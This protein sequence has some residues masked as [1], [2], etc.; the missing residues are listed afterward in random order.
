MIFPS[1]TSRKTSRTIFFVR[2]RPSISGT[3]ADGNT[4]FAGEYAYVGTLSLGG[5]MEGYLYKSASQDAGEFTYFFMMPDTPET[6]CHLEFRYGSNVEALTLYN[7]GPYA[8][9]LAAGFPVDADEVMTENVISLFCL[10]NLD[11]S[12]HTEDAL[13]QLEALGF[14]GK[15]VADLS[16]FGEAYAQTELYFTIDENGHGETYMNGVQTRDFEAFAA[17]TGEAG[18]GYGLYVAYDNAENEPEGAEYS[19]LADEN[20]RTVL[21]FYAEDGVISYVK[22][23]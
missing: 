7:E 14:T 8:Y 9:W 4:V 16:A 1:L 23:D 13:E 20:G 3:D 2:S 15:W 21:T 5:M 11:Y 22:A 6:T 18:D 17:D 12:A 19:L 10:E